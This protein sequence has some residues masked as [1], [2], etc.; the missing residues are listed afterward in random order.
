[1]RSFNL[2]TPFYDHFARRQDIYTPP[3]NLPAISQLYGVPV[4]AAGQSKVGRDTPC[5]PVFAAGHHCQPTFGGQGTARPANNGGAAT[6]ACRETGPAPH[7][8]FAC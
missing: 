6:P 2:K 4:F 7:R 5:A 8:L 1:M 3:M